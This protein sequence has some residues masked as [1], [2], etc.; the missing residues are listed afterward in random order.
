MYSIGVDLG[1]TNIVAGV[2]DDNY[3][4]LAT[5]K[6]K[7]NAPRSAELILEDMATLSREAVKKAGLS[8][9]KIAFIGIGSPG[10]CNTETGVVEYT[11]NLDFN[12]VPICRIMH[13]KLGLPVYIETMPMPPHWARRWQVPLK[14]PTAVCVLRWAPVSVVALSLTERFTRVSILPV[15]K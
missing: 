6:C 12:N 15:Q 11:N 2:V 10:T 1:G 4:I 9:D 14:V 3:R 8:M 5:A 7:T 13:E